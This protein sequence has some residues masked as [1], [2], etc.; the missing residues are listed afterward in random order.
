MAYFVL[1]NCENFQMQSNILCFIEYLAI[2]K[3]RVATLQLSSCG[4]TR[5]RTGDTRIFSP[6]LYQLSY[7][8]IFLFVSAKVG[9]I[10]EYGKLLLTFLKFIRFYVEF[11]QRKSFTVSGDPMIFSRC[12]ASP[13]RQV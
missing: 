3:K 5:N 11:S 13:V 1:E 7:G 4:A 12:P 9:L 8:T 10:F 2:K 6:L